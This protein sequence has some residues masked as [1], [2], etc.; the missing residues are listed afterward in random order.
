MNDHERQPAAIVLFV[1]AYQ[2]ARVEATRRGL[3]ITAWRHASTPHEVERALSGIDR[4]AVQVL[5]SVHW[6]DRNAL[7]L[8]ARERAEAMGFKVEGVL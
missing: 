2:W 5:A 7:I 3:S 8:S 6:C 1:G 4:A